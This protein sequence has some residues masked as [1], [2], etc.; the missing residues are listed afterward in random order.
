MYAKSATLN[1][2]GLII[3]KNN[4]ADLGVI[5]LEEIVAIFS[6]TIIFINNLGSLFILKSNVNFTGNCTFVNCSSLRTSKQLGEYNEAGAITSYQST[7]QI[8]G[9]CTLQYNY[10][11]NGGAVYGVKSVLS[12][13]EGEILIAN[14]VA[15]DS[16]GGVYLYQCQLNCYTHGPRLRTIMLKIQG[17]SADKGGGIHAIDSSINIDTP[18]YPDSFYLVANRAKQGGGIFME[19]NSHLNVDLRFSTLILKENSAEYYGGAIYIADGTNPGTCS[20]IAYGTYTE[21][22]LQVLE[23]GVNLASTGLTPDSLTFI[24]NYAHIS[25]HNLYGGLLNRCTIRWTER[26]VGTITMNGLQYLRNII[27][28]STDTISSNSV[29]VCF[30]KA[31]QPDCSY[32]PSPIRVKKGFTFAVSLIAANQVNHTQSYAAIHSYLNS[33][34][35]HLAK[36]QLTQVTNEAC[37]DLLFNVHSLHKSEELTLYAEGPCKDARLSQGRIKIYFLPCECPVGF[38]GVETTTSCECKCD[39]ALLPYVTDCDASVG[40]LVREGEFWISNINYSDY[41]IFP[42]C[43]LDYCTRSK[44]HI[45][46][47]STDEADAQCINHRSGKLCGSCQLSFSLSL[48][49]SRCVVCSS[50]WPAVF[51]AILIAA[52]LAGIALVALL[53]VLN[54]T[55]AVGTLN[56]IIFNANILD[57]NSSVFFQFTTNFVTVLIAW[58]NLELGFDI[59]FF[60]GM[61]SYWKTWLQLLFPAYIIVLVVMIIFISERSTVFARLIG[62][63]NPVATLATLILLSYTKLLRTVIAALSFAISDGSHEVVWLSDASVGYLSGKHIPLFIVAILILLAGVVYTAVLISWQWLLHYQNKVIFRWVRNQRLHLFLEPY[64]APYTFKHRYWTGLLL[65]VRVVLYLH[66]VSVSTVVHEPARWNLLV[67]TIVMICLLLPKLLLGIR[68]Y[69][70]LSIDV[71]ETLSYLYYLIL[72]C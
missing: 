67:I 17:N 70:K 44:T 3:I 60:E 34:E 62:R 1:M 49:S 41:L 38:Q 23:R 63:K 19:V 15:T 71:L 14:N 9:A 55:V 11:L 28:V 10:A 35:S 65:L 47:N 52:I 33:T 42:H 57:A 51:T 64:H 13:Y 25:G 54:L 32:Q 59:C 53:L 37:S 20:S 31:G 26:L 61:D 66:T 48:G 18:Y 68:I 50:H 72:C 40:S 27:N 12:I 69:K 7:I 24:G 56:G 43:P 58:F 6:G 5:Y 36:G 39:S 22:F 29:Q 30:C 46:L 16:G 45:H 8:T 21:C 2:S 4:M